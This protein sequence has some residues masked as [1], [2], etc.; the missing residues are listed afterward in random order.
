MIGWGRERYT[1]RLETLIEDIR[2]NA[3]ASGREDE[4]GPGADTAQ[5][6]AD[7]RERASQQVS[8]VQSLLSLVREFLELLPGEDG[9]GKVDFAALCRGV[10]EL[11]GKF[12]SLYGELDAEA[13]TLLRTKL[14]DAAAFKTAPLRR[15]TA[16]DWLKNVGAGLTVGA[17]GPSPGHLHLS[18]WFSGGRSARPVTFVAGLDQGAFPGAGIQ[19]P[20]LLDEERERLNEERKAPLLRTTAES[21]RENLW[22]MAAMLAGLGGRVTLSYSAYDI[23]EERPSFPSSVILQAARLVAGKPDMD[24]SALAS[25]FPEAQAFLPGEDKKAVDETDW[26]LARL[27]PGGLLRDGMEAVKSNFDALSRGIFARERREKPSSRIRGKTGGSA[28]VHPLR[29]RRW[30]FALRT[31]G[32]THFRHVL[33]RARRRARARRVR[34]LSRLTGAFH[35]VYAARR[36]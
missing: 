18:T 3:D 35:E 5:D 31:P 25:L 24:Y 10:A 17:S 13:R 28:E 4:G 15:L 11:I 14:D 2:T 22:R 16:F 26:W 12:A 9:S 6:A 34:W 1:A 29:I 21:L 7:R 20:I 27:A 23:I 32:V 19:D 33:K 36:R 30:L 8:E